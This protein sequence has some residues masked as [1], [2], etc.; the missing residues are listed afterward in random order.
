VNQRPL[1]KTGLLVSEIAFGGVEI[2]IPYGIGIRSQA[3]MLSDA[4]AVRLLQAALDRGINF[5]DTAC[6]YGRSEELMG[7]AFRD[8][9]DQAI[10]CTKC[11][12]MPAPNP[13]SGKALQALIDDGLRA[14]LTALQTDYIDLYQVHD[15]LMLGLPEV[16]ELFLDYKKRGIARAI[17][18]STY[19]VEETRRAIESGV[20]DSVQLPFNLMDQRQAAAFPLARERGVGIV[21]RSVLFKGILTDRGRNL[22]PA[23]KAVE[24]HRKAYEP[25]LSTEAPT[26]SALATR[27]VLS[28]PEVSSVLLG[29]DRMQYLDQAV[30]ASG[31]CLDAATKARAELLA[32]PDPAFL[33]LPLW[34]R[35]GWLR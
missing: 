25:L 32:Y 2:G 34:D 23:L 21:V 6:T 24:G 8:R 14:S 27:F 15:P 29:I 19:Q 28:Y 30:A 31:T 12:H 4:D 35:K 1:G 16:A 13:P 20:W 22:H 17:G 33:D 5:F 9:R 3:D 11:P 7:R 10:I 18:I 26:L